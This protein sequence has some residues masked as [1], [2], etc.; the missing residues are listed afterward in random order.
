MNEHQTMQFKKAITVIL[1]LL[2]F[3]IIYKIGYVKGEANGC[4]L[5]LDFVNQIIDNQIK[6]DTS[7]SELDILIK[8]DTVGYF[9]CPKT[10]LNH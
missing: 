9:L 2:S 8:K 1:F 5:T 10:I 3:Y 7:I 6:S 4:L